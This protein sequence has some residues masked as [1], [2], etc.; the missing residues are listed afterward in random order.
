[1]PFSLT[2]LILHARMLYALSNYVGPLKGECKVM[3][4]LK[5]VTITPSKDEDTLTGIA[6]I[7]FTRSCFDLHITS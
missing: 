6:Q 7:D 2:R 1:V 5:P 4:K 3:P